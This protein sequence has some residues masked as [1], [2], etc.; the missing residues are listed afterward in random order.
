MNIKIIVVQLFVMACLVTQAR[1]KISIN[2][3]WKFIRE[4]I[5]G[6]EKPDFDDSKW[7]TVDLPHDAA[8]YGVFRKNGNGASSRVGYLEQKRGWYRRHVQY[9]RKWQG[10]RVVIEFEGVYRDAK[11]YI[12][13]K[14]CEGQVT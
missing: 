3:G 7:Q 4:N 2:M 5:T 8:V 9:N 13:G 12:N 10:Q 11:V 1:D 6:A 14:L